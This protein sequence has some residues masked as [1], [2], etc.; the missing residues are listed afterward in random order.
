[1]PKAK[2]EWREIYMYTIY[3]EYIRSCQTFNEENEKRFLHM[4]PQVAIVYNFGTNVALFA[5]PFHTDCHMPI[6]ASGV[7]IFF[8]TFVARQQFLLSV[9]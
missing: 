1:M 5:I 2:L 7:G 9:G 8:I 3:P 6:K 4:S